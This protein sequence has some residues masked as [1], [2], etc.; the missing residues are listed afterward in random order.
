MSQP[1]SQPSLFGLSYGWSYVLSAFTL[2]ICCCLPL[3]LLATMGGSGTG[4]ERAHALLTWLPV[5][6][7][8]LAAGSALLYAAYLRHNTTWQRQVLMAMW[9]FSAL[10]MVGWWK[11]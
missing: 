3:A 5:M 9:A 6:A 1:S 11:L 10:G 2:T 4:V 7:G 8:I